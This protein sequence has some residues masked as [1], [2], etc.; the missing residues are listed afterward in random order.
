[1]NRVRLVWVS[2]TLMVLVRADQA[3]LSHVVQNEDNLGLQTLWMVLKGVVGFKLI[4]SVL[5]PGFHVSPI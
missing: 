4:H 3:I 2:E 5:S 1:M